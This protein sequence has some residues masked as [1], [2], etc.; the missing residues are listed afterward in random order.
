[1][2]FLARF[3]GPLL[4]TAAGT[5][6]V[7]MLLIWAQLFFWPAAGSDLD[8]TS[9][10]K[11]TPGEIGRSLLWVGATLH[12]ASLGGQGPLLFMV[13][14]GTVGLFGWILMVTYLM[15]GRKLAL[16]G[17]AIMAPVALA[18]LLFSLTAPKLHAATPPGG[19]DAFWL[20]TH[21]F[22]ILAAY[23]ALA[24]AFAASL[25]YLVQ[26]SL[27]KRKQLSGLWLKLPSLQVADDWILRATSFGLALLTMGIFTGILYFGLQ[28]PNYKVAQD[29]KVLFS[30]ATWLAFAIYL[31]CRL[32]LGWHG[33]R[34]N[35]VVIY[36]FM[37]LVISFLGTPHLIPNR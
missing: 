22:I 15:I 28:V 37:L 18:A 21:V 30:F 5:Y 7:A 17:A 16:G 35:M 4:L 13:K 26:E 2:N 14:A 10:T 29:P 9:S 19:F 12:L 11:K 23:V 1:M 31:V 34:A 20:A 27:L 8:G 6:L 25:L 3:E 24:F 32:W 33:R 36:G